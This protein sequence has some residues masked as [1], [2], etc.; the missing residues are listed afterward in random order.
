MAGGMKTLAKET[1]IYGVSSILGK[2]LNWLLTPLW[3]YVLINQSQMGEVGLL[4]SWTALIIVVL[5]Y[6]METGLF[7][8][9]NKEKENPNTVYSTTLI[10]IG[11]TSLLFVAVAILFLQPFSTVFGSPNIKPHYV[12]L[13]TIILGLDA[14]S[15]IPFAYLR[16]QKRPIRFASIQ[17][18]NVV[19]TIV[20]NLFFFVACPWL[21]VKFPETFA[22]FDIR[23]GVDFILISNLLASSI[24]LLLL[25]PQLNVKYVFDAK[26]L[27]KMLAYSLPLLVLGFAGIMNQIL[28]KIL[29]P[30]LST[31]PDFMEQL[32]VY[33]ASFK[34]AVI[35][36]MFAQAFRYAFEPFIFAKNKEPGND[37]RNAYSEAT[38]YFILFGL[39]IFLAV[40]GYMDIIKYL[41]KSTYHEGLQIVPIVMIGELFFGVYF[42]LSLWYKLTDKTQWGTYLSIFGL[43]ITLAIN[44]LFVPQ[45]GYMACAWASFF[46]NVAMMLASY[47]LG[48]KYYPINYNLKS[49]A[50]FFALA[51]VLYAGIALSHR[52]VG[53]VWLRLLINSVI[54]AVYML[55]VIKKEVPLREIPVIGRYFKK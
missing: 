38:R 21:A 19:A 49:A 13:L 8:F 33:S 29:Y 23:N 43:A 44:I 48:Q 52:Y 6:G 41:L 45:F 10:S 32:G 47:F 50:T 24:R 30:Y 3:S 25:S 40:T 42:N 20:F 22:W 53:S 46:A 18:L 34:I 7:R 5:T 55:A 39:L 27:R 31:E 2:F 9:A 36:V 15:A 54:V 28:D 26:L 51:L 17:I 11:A 1:A 35:M 4:Y 14:F 16:F 12:L 37:N